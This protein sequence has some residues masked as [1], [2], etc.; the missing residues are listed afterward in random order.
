MAGGL[1]FFVNVILTTL[2]HWQDTISQDVGN[3]YSDDDDGD[4]KGLRDAKISQIFMNY[5]F[6]IGI[7]THKLYSCGGV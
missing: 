4:S 6:K 1:N 7:L 2:C 5:V 3:D